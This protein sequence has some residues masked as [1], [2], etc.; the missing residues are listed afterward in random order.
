LI[1]A[2]DIETRERL[3]E[4]LPTA[5]LARIDFPVDDWRNRDLMEDCPPQV[6]CAP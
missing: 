3:N 6:I 1:A 2:G 5:G 4:G